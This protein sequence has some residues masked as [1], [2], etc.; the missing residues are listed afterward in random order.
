MRTLIA[1]L[2]AVFFVSACQTV[3]QPAPETPAPVERVSCP[4]NSFPVSTLEG[5]LERHGFQEA[6]TLE[7]DVAAVVVRNFN[8]LPPASDWSPDRAVVYVNRSH[9]LLVF[10][11][12][13]CVTGPQPM[14]FGHFER[15]MR[16]MVGQGV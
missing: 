7:R 2:V 15:F 8:A 12:G 16:Q 10:F 3:E 4:S 13:D 1:A 11:L 9:G 6:Y 5:F 14:P